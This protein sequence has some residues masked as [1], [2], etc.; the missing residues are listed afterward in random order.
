M[1]PLRRVRPEKQQRRQI[2]TE[3]PP[4]DQSH[5]RRRSKNELEGFRVKERE[6][7]LKTGKRVAC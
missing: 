2:P 5:T 6:L 7:K 3:S 4:N 1:G